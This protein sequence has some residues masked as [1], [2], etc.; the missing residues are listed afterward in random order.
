MGELPEVRIDTA[1]SGYHYDIPA[2]VKPVFIQTVNLPQ[3]TTHTI[4]NHRISQLFAGSDPHPIGGRTIGLGIKHQISIGMSG[5]GIEAPENMIQL[6][7]T[8][9]FHTVSP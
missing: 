9:K 8:G 5:G 2:G 4:P 7:R 3:T 6:Q 1:A